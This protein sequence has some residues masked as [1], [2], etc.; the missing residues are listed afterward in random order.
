MRLLR[1]MNLLKSARNVAV[2]DTQGCCGR[3]AGFVAG[4]AQGCCGRRA[5]SARNMRKKIKSCNRLKEYFGSSA[6]CY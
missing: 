1:K 6:F 5:R 3:R 4:G 2:E